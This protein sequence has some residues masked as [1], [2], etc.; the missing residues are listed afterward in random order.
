MYSKW[1]GRWQDGAS[2]GAIGAILP[3]GN[4]WPVSGCPAAVHGRQTIFAE[5]C[6]GSAS[7]KVMKKFDLNANSQMQT[8]THG[9]EEEDPPPPTPHFVPPH[10]SKT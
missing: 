1:D 2:G 3:F 4:T 5:G 9:M 10:F 8:Y 6:R 7:M